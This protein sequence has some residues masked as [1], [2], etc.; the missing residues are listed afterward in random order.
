MHPILIEAMP[1]PALSSL[2]ISLKILLSIIAKNIMLPGHIKHLTRLCAF[3]DLVYGIEFSRL[4]KMT[5]VTCVN[6]KRWLLWQGIDFRDSL[7]K[8]CSYIWIRR[9]IESHVAVAY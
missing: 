5:D 3:E 7:L 9:F 2:A 1:A 6:E 4:G 8:C